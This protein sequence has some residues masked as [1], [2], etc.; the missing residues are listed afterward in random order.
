[1]LSF[2]GIL[3]AAFVSVAIVVLACCRNML[4]STGQTVGREE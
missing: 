2:T 4:A 3:S 1:M